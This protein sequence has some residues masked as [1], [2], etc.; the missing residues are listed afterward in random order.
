M[1]RARR[2]ELAKYRQQIDAEDKEL[3]MAERALTRVAADTTSAVAPAV[4]MSGSRRK[5]CDRR[6]S[7]YF[8]TV[9]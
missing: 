4:V 1:I 6:H 5:T 3:E 7:G 2:T 9:L 8:G